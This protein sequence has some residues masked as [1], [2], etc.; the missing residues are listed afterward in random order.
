MEENETSLVKY[1]TRSILA[2]ETQTDKVAG[3][4]NSSSQSSFLLLFF[5]HDSD[6]IKLWRGR[7]PEKNGRE[8][9]WH[10]DQ[11]SITHLWCIK[12]APY[13]I[14]IQYRTYAPS[15]RES[16]WMLYEWLIKQ[17]HCV[18]LLCVTHHIHCKKLVP[19]CISIY[20]QG[21]SMTK[22]RTERETCDASC[23]FGILMSHA[24]LINFLISVHFQFSFLHP[25]WCFCCLASPVRLS[26]FL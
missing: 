23:L 25:N 16:I 3:F 17:R 10:K 15:A 26:H 13:Y 20:L 7:G 6:Q 19:S 22:I 8:C 24:S 2:W 1:L 14:V 4:H 18:T 21:E 11:I 5:I 9:K 12:Q